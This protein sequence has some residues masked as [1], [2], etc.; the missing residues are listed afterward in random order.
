MAAPT[1]GANSFYSPAKPPSNVPKVK[2]PAGMAPLNPAR[3]DADYESFLT[4]GGAWGQGNYSNPVPASQTNQW[5]NTQTSSTP[6]VTQPVE[7]HWNIPDYNALLAGDWEPNDAVITGGKMRGEAEAGF[8]AALRR[9]FIDFGGDSSKL[10]NWA[11]YIDQPTIEAAQANKFSQTAQ[12]LAAMT[13]NMRQSRAALAARGLTSSGQSTE[14]AKLAL[15]AKQL[16][17]VT[18]G[19]TFTDLAESGER[20]LGKVETDI[21]AMI[22]AA[23]SRA[24]ARIAQEHPHTW[25]P[26]TPGYE[27]GSTT[28]TTESG[29]S[30]STGVPGAAA[31]AGTVNWAGKQMNAQQLAA[32]LQRTGVNRATWIKN[33]PAAARQIGWA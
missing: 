27:P 10:G 23:R 18:A 5:S 22:D 14:N 32:E 13:K 29:S 3:S 30:S 4:G 2:L 17:D 26:G 12:N 31:A 15:E 24:A 1:Y 8:Q 6:A 7:G 16:A 11:K 20:G 25:D 28:T 21:A 33:H 9:A 19:R